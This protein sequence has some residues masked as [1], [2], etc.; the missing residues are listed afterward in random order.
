M[1]RVGA[2]L[3]RTDLHAERATG[4]ILGRDLQR[5]ALVGELGGLEGG[6][7][8]GLRCAGEGFWSEKLRSDGG[9]RA[10]EGALVALD[11]D[12]GVPLR[13]LQ[14]DVALLEAGGSSRPG[15]VARNGAHRHEIALVG[16]Q[17]GGDLAHELRS[18][19]VG[20]RK[21]DRGVRVRAGRDADL[22]QASEGGVDRR[23]V[24]LDDLVA[25]AAV[26]LGDRLFDLGDGLVLRQHAREGEEAGLQHRVG[27]AAH[28]A[29]LGD[30]RGVDHE[31]ADAFV[32]QCLLPVAG[33]PFPGLLRGV[34][35]VEQHRGAR[36]G[37]A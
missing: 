24:H 37:V 26:R 35:G 1:S 5:V 34:G 4:A 7:L 18:I 14:R 13:N 36:S 27:P 30:L 23:V 9:V 15:A 3:G 29:G 32:D 10:N 12:R 22:L 31:E 2:V 21:H 20:R 19:F 28:A 11:T 33:Q 16:E 8:E 17:A 6:G 25:L